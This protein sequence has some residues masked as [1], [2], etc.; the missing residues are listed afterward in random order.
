VAVAAEE[1]GWFDSNFRERKI[2]W[3]YLGIVAAVCAICFVAVKVQ[4]QH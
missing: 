2:G 1:S 3:V 4:E